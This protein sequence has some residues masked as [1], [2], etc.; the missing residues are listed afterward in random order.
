MPSLLAGHQCP[1]SYAFV[2]DVQIT[3]AMSLNLVESLPKG[4]KDLI[5]AKGCFINT[6]EMGFS[7][8]KCPNTFGHVVY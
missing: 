2:A 6:H 8:V 1:I 7:M 3:T 4:V 5:I